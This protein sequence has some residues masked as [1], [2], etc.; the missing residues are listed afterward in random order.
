MQPQEGQTTVPMMPAQ[1][2]LYP[3][4]YPAQAV[5]MASSVDGASRGSVFS[6]GSNQLFDLRNAGMKIC[7][8][9]GIRNVVGSS[10]MDVW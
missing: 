8:K 5:P 10:D 6:G 3:A 9:C 2:P 1:A 4:Q 7:F